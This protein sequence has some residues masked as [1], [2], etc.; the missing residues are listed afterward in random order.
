MERR[1]QRRAF[2]ALRDIGAPEISHRF[3][4]GAG[5]NDRGIAD[6]QREAMLSIG[7]VPQSL[8]VAADRGDIIRRQLCAAQ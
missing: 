5:G 4:A 2:A 6:L 1:H 7:A 8:A 3:D